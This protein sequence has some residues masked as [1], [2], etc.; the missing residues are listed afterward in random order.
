MTMR[1][2]E[3]SLDSSPS[4]DDFPNELLVSILVHIRPG[5]TSLHRVCS[6]WRHLTHSDLLCNAMLHHWFGNPIALTRQ[7]PQDSVD[8]PL[9]IINSR[10][11]TR[12]EDTRLLDSNT[13]T[14]PYELLREATRSLAAKTRAREPPGRM[15]LWAAGR[16]FDALVHRMLLEHSCSII[17]YLD[18]DTGYTALLLACRSDWIDVVR[19][20]LAFKPDL[21]VSRA[22]GL[23]SLHLAAQYSSGASI[24]EALIDAKADINARIASSARKPICI[25]AEHNNLEAVRALLRRHSPHEILDA[26]RPDRPSILVQSCRSGSLELLQLLVSVVRGVSDVASLDRGRPTSVLHESA[27]HHRLDLLQYWLFDER[28]DPNLLDYEGH[29]ALCCACSLPASRPSAPVVELLLRANASLDAHR[30]GHSLLQVAVSRGHVATVECLLSHGA[31][32]HVGVPQHQQQQQQQQQQQHS[33]LTCALAQAARD[34]TSSSTRVLELLLRHFA[35]E[36]LHSDEYR[37]CLPLAIRVASEP[38][39]AWLD[40]WCKQH[41]VSHLAP[42]LSERLGCSMQ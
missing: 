38:N 40:H 28:L 35:A 23:T 27:R 24:I 17:D 12:V 34:S 16:G 25:A 5:S 36:L 11:R 41:N 8:R 7:R 13:A 26:Q 21:T 4:F 39:R 42:D 19:V 14:S 31:L 32:L 33:S 10:R 6:R 30:C 20:L 22:V 1:P 9:M 3:C 18:P 29:S 15:L 37:H 2:D